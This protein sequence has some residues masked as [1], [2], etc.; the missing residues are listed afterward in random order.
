MCYIIIT[1]YEGLYI[2]NKNKNLPVS[3]ENIK[4]N[5]LVIFLAVHTLKNWTQI[6]FY[7]QKKR[8]K[9]IF[10]RK[11]RLISKSFVER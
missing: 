6:F 1:E 5:A 4:G 11:T 9:Y 10:N 3:E 8:T 7:L 2:K